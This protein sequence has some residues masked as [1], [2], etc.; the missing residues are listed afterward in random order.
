MKGLL[1]GLLAFGLIVTAIKLDRRRVRDRHPSVRAE[2]DKWEGEGE[3][4]PS[5]TSILPRRRPP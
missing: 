2:I 5:A 3:P 1:L 4:S